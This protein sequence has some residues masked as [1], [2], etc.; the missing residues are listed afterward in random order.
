MQDLY[1][2][3]TRKYRSLLELQD[4]ALSVK[5][6]KRRDRAIKR[7]NRLEKEKTSLEVE[8]TSPTNSDI[9]RKQ[10]LT[11]SARKTLALGKR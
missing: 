10:I 9:A 1:R 6:K 2:K 11:R 7:N 3:S 5:E 8:A 4:K